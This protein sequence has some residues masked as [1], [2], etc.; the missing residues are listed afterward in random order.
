LW[1][2]SFLFFWDLIFVF[3]WRKRVGGGMAGIG[4]GHVAGWVTCVGSVPAFFVSFLVLALIVV[5]Y[6]AIFTYCQIWKERM[7]ERKKL[8][9]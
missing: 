5:I 1:N 7:N 3:I 4:Y 8:L 6:F 2:F 9:R